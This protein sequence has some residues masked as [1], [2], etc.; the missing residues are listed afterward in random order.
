[1]AV[2]SIGSSASREPKILRQFVDLLDQ[3]K[4]DLPAVVV[5]YCQ[6]EVA[7]ILR[8]NRRNHARC[9]ACVA[10]AAAR[11]EGCAPS[12]GSAGPLNMPLNGPAELGAQPDECTKCVALRNTFTEALHDWW[13]GKK[14]GVKNLE[15][16]LPSMADLLQGVLKEAEALV[17]NEAIRVRREQLLE[18]VSRC[19]RT[20]LERSFRTDSREFVRRAAEV[21]PEQWDLLH[22]TQEEQIALRAA[23]GAEEQGME[24]PAMPPDLLQRIA[25]MRQQANATRAEQRAPPTHLALWRAADAKIDEL[26]VMLRALA[27]NLG[28]DAL[29]SAAS[30]DAVQVLLQERLPSAYSVEHGVKFADV[31][32]EAKISILRELRALPRAS[33]P[34]TPNTPAESALLAALTVLEQH[35]RRNLHGPF[36]SVP[37]LRIEKM[38]AKQKELVLKHMQVLVPGG[39]DKTEA[40]RMA[41]AA[42]HG[43]NI[44][45]DM[46]R[47]LKQAQAVVLQTSARYMRQMS[48]LI[49]VVNECGFGMYSREWKCWWVTCGL[50]NVKQ[51]MQRKHGECG[52]YVYYAN[53]ACGEHY[54]G[55]DKMWWTEYTGDTHPFG[56]PTLTGLLLDAW[57]LGP[58][59]QDM[60][61][62]SI[63]YVRSS[64]A[65]SFFG[66]EAR[67][68]YKALHFTPWGYEL[69]ATC[70]ALRWNERRRN[71]QLAASK[72]VISKT[73]Q[74]G[75][76][77]KS[78]GTAHLVEEWRLQAQEA[79]LAGSPLVARFTTAARAVKDK[80]SKRRGDFCDADKARAKRVRQA[81]EAASESATRRAQAPSLLMAFPEESVVG[82]HVYDGGKIGFAA[83]GST[84]R[85]VQDW[86]PHPRPDAQPGVVVE[87]EEQEDDGVA[88]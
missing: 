64:E 28:E 68:L 14:R 13:H 50:L 69:G 37:D 25:A 44:F 18:I 75:V 47:A 20:T 39:T 36:V 74:Q 1:M 42:A 46:E 16:H 84:L 58:W 35:R 48:T 15:K 19:V 10:L 65:E 72:V 17:R 2:M 5:D 27:P 3:E 83:K 11:V 87:V 88:P 61:A 40:L 55:R 70:L 52:K 63:L 9:A 41:L 81:G 59:L 85:A 8:G 66:A 62:D 67:W 23:L 73:L 4:V 22:G 7:T 76:L 80:A 45:A 12:P 32:A 43:E 53:C 60:L 54:T 31:M 51:H 56:I 86:R 24:M 77:R 30:R 21:P 38:D 78:A 34:A 26:Q 49:R 29:R 6:G 33:A 82:G 57:S 79:I 71:R